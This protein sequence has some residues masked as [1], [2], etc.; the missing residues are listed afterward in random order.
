MS[1]QKKYPDFLENQA[2]FF[3]ELITTEWDTYKSRDW[4]DART[5]EVAQIFRR[6]QPRSIIDI[7][8]GCGFHDLVMAKSPFVDS[9]V[10]IDYS[11]AS[12][13]TAEREYPHAKIERFQA[14]IAS[15]PPGNFDM[16]VSFHVIEHL[17][18]PVAFMRANMAQVRPGGWVVVVTP[19]RMR[20]E[21]LAR[22]RRGKPLKL[23]D[24]QHF[25]EFTA[26]EIAEMGEALGLKVVDV[27]GA[28]MRWKPKLLK[29][30]VIPARL[31]LHLGAWIP[32][33]A[34]RIGVIFQ[35]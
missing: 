23:E 9:V 21:N 2:A 1:T 28:G 20:L 5:F 27:F 7:G 14:D 4:D 19:N 30:Q 34:M 25:Q 33:V 10:G 17:S 13:E 35:K 3:D 22:F 6:I 16:A 32:S 31:G 11:A 24:P 26:L 8:C 15:M 29:R 12:I 18:D